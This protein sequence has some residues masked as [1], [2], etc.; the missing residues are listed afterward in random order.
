MTVGPTAPATLPPPGLCGLDPAWSRLVSARDSHGR[1]RTWHVLDT[2]PAD[3][4]G[5]LLCVHG[6]PTWSY[7]W[8]SVAARLGDRW[9]VVAVDHLGMGYS[10]RTGEQHRLAD[11]VA[12]LGAVTRALDVS[13]PVVTVGHDWGGSISLGW[14]LDHPGDLTGVV[15]TNT[16]V[17]QPDDARL[18]ALIAAARTPGVLRTSTV[19]TAAF[20]QGTLRLAHPSLPVEVRRAYAAPYRR[21]ADRQAVG[22]F[23]DDIPLAPADPSFATL[24]SIQKRLSELAQ[25]PALLLWGPRDPV[26]SDR[27]LRD[28][29]RRLPQAKLHRFPNAGHLVV[30]DAPVA[31]AIEQ[32]VDTLARQPAADGAS[33]DTTPGAVDAPPR[34][35]PLRR[36]LWSAL[37][38]RADDESPAVVELSAGG[39][40]VSWRQLAQRVHDLAS[41]LVQHGVEPGDRV[42]LLVTPGADLTAVLYAC[43]QMG[44][45]VVVADAGLGLKGLR[46]ALQ[47]ADVQHVVGVERGL[48]AARLMGLPGQLVAAGPVSGRVSALTRPT[49]TLAQVALDGRALPTPRPPS[50]EAEAAVLFTSGATGPA[51]GVVYRHRQLEA[52]RDAVATLFGITGQDRLVAAFAPF[53]LYGPALGIASAVPDMDVTAPATLTATALAE[54]VEAIDATV[55]FGSPAALRN[56]VDTADQLDSGAR[57]ALTQVR[58]L[59]SAGA[60]VPRDTLR[61]AARLLGDCEAHTPYGMTEVLPVADI[62]L[63]Q[64]DAVG[65]GSGVCV[66]T[67]LKGVDVAVSPLSSSGAADGGLTMRAEVTGEIVVRADHVK[68]HYDQLWSTQTASARDAGWHRTGD[69]GHLDAQGRLWVEGRLAHVVVTADGVVT[70]VGVEQRVE[71]VDAVTLAAVVGVGPVGTQQVVVVVETSPRSRRPGLAPLALADQVRAAVGGVDVA[72]VLVTPRLP[73]DV[74]HNSKIDRAQVARWAEQLLAG[75]KAPRR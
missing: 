49:T 39:R 63:G 65:T 64:L 9:R 59:L 68:D 53:A 45:V 29:Q 75:R 23:V 20:V 51:K 38:A 60:P 30:D 14:A 74:R 4:V 55:V 46:E 41:G 13:G 5:T 69:V 17:A 34:E 21:A 57:D 58:A 66:G 37:D 11:R 22:D 50:A 16:A 36:P 27:Y 31:E 18:P 43:W 1:L 52:Q 42:A 72:A 48:L 24:T 71:Q 19:R 61:A 54:A 8:R 35:A 44:A 10:E 25:V 2:A 62:T 15:L 70:P 3:P 12:E 33:T 40:T 56:V 6:N 73:V 26:F 67:P 32:F 28:V 7:L 47:G